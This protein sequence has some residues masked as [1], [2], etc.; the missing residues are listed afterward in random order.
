MGVA[1]GMSTSLSSMY[2]AELSPK[3][4][5]GFLTSLT[6]QTLSGGLIFGFL[7]AGLASLN[8]RHHA[9]FGL[10][11]PLLGLLLAPLLAESPRWLNVRGRAEEAE[12]VVRAYVEDQAE[13]EQTLEGF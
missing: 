13:V 5:R 6:E 10:L 12:A 8:F 7:V 3:A 4:H 1:S 11:F 2:I 9:F